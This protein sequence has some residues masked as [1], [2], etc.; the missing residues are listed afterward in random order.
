MLAYGYGG[1]WFDMW[2]GWFSDPKMLKVLQSSTEWYE[3]YPPQQN[4]PLGAQVAVLVDEELA[5]WDA[6]YGSLTQ[7]ILS[8][9]SPLAKSGAPY[10]LY[11]SSDCDSIVEKP[12]QMIWLMGLLHLTD[13]Q[14]QSV[15]RWTQAGVTVMW[16]NG[17]G[18]RI[19]YPDGQKTW[20]PDKLQWTDKELNQLW[21][22]TGVHL[23]TN[24]GDVL[25]A[26]Q[27]WLSLHTIEGGVREIDLPFSARVYDPVN[28]RVIADSSQRFHIDLAEKS[29]TVLRVEER[30]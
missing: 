16:T 9:W 3:Q 8:N 13:D 28:Q 27:G 2:G 24:P 20:I 10:H 19:Y 5:F 26:G 1:W 29:T 22:R 21:Q 4:D 25:Y 17:S 30:K 15:E 14:L 6:S 23:Y 11:L 12:Y 18:S 7:E